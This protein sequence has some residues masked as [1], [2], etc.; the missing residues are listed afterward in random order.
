MANKNRGENMNNK[1]LLLIIALI[2]IP[3]AL[4][5]TCYQ[6]ID[7]RGS[8]WGQG[9]SSQQYYGISDTG[10]GISSCDITVYNSDETIVM[11]FNDPAVYNAYGQTWFNSNLWD[12]YPA[13]MPTE[14]MHT[15]ISCTYL[16]N[17]CTLDTPWTLYD[18]A[19]FTLADTQ[20]ITYG[21]NATISYY[22]APNFGSMAIWFEYN[23]SIDFYDE[24]H[25]LVYTYSETFFPSYHDSSRWYNITIGSGSGDI[26]WSVFNNVSQVYAQEG[27]AVRI[28]NLGLGTY[29]DYVQTGNGSMNVTMPEEICGNGIVGP[30]EIC[31]GLNLSGSTCNTFGWFTGTLICN[32]TCTG[33][34]FT[35]CTNCSNNIIEPIL[36]EVCDGTNLN[37]STCITLGWLKGTLSCN[38][39]CTDFIQTSCS[40]STGGGGGGFP[41]TPPIVQP[42]TEPPVFTVIPV[43]TTPIDFGKFFESWALVFEKLFATPLEAI[44]LAGTAA[45]SY[46]IELLIT[47][48]VIGGLIYMGVSNKKPKRK[49]K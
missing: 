16:S 22:L 21:T 6:I 32:S 48:A 43:K 39:T 24:L 11:S 1:I 33:Y 26:D 31:D 45:K 44:T 10:S 46:W 36:G 4:A 5:Y 15:N 9:G 3:Q 8:Y 17:H 49:K 28:N 25:N 18:D 37:G 12:A 35:A 42:P 41:E 20:G 38:P 29:A 27:R 19:T 14:S 40:N 2:I 13:R 30:G 47:I 34:N 23:V 7:D